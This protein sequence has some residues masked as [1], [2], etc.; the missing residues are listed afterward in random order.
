[1][2]KEKESSVHG[3]GAPAFICQTP[4]RAILKSEVNA[5]FAAGQ[6]PVPPK[7]ALPIPSYS[8]NPKI[9]LLLSLTTELESA[10][11]G[12]ERS[13]VRHWTCTDSVSYRILKFSN[14]K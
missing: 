13:D 2:G 6:T 4:A 1:M 14:R 5:S 7:D 12:G 8:P 11:T 3:T 10:K 9:R